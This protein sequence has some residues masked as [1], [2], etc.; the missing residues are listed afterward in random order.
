MWHVRAVAYVRVSTGEQG[1]SG[2][3][4]AAQHSTIDREIEHR[5]WELI[6][7]YE[8]VASGKTIKGRTGLEDALAALKG[9][10]ADVLLVA[11]LDRL[12]RS[13][14]DFAGLLDRARTEGWSVVALDVDVDTTTAAGEMMATVLMALAQWERKIIGER[15]KAALDELV[16]SGV[17]LGR[18]PATIP[19][20]TRAL[21]WKLRVR[22]LSL[23]AVAA[24]LPEPAPGGGK[25]SATAVRRI[26]PIS[27]A[28][29]RAVRERDG[30]Q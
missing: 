1:D 2:L 29:L 9:G 22:G 16:K 14:S 26:T 3:G 25:W 8:D 21:A 7:L 23:R 15:T 11:K 20:S 10:F 13:V 5:G 17:R 6:R 19:D 28:E 27:Q 30:V 12:S 18:P 24:L 4:I